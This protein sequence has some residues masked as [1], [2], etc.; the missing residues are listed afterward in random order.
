M[1]PDDAPAEFK[2]KAGENTTCDDVLRICGA[3]AGL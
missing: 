2:A 3:D 1:T